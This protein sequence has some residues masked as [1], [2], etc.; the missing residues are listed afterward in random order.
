MNTNGG[1]GLPW[2]SS[3]RD[4][5]LIPGW[6][7]KIPYDLGPKNQSRK[8]KQYFNKVFNKDFLNGPIQKKKK[9]GWVEHDENRK[10]LSPCSETDWGQRTISSYQ[11]AGQEPFQALLS[12]SV[13]Q[14]QQ[15]F[16]RLQ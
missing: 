1:W 10:L 7:A 2:Q 14:R 6:E 12:S 11:V 15:L 16:P 3:V 5:G 13:K 9:G 8:H 4:M